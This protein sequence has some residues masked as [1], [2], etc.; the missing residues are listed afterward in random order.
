MHN[1]LCFKLHDPVRSELHV[2][3]CAQLLSGAVCLALG[4]R[5]HRLLRRLLLRQ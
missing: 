5:G 4:V 2:S 3:M 1:S